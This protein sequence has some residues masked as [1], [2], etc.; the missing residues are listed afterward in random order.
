LDAFA[1]FFA[2]SEEDKTE[3]ANTTNG[4]N[5]ATFVTGTTAISFEQLT[6]LSKLFG[7]HIEVKK[8]NETAGI[9]TPAAAKDP[10]KEAEWAEKVK[11][12]SV[13]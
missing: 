10:V 6:A 7:G 11:A 3:P 4:F 13:S 5:M 12:P 1:N 9:S 8:R 2:D